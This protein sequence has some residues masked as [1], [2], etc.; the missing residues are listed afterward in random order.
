MPERRK[1]PVEPVF[2]TAAPVS[3][4]AAPRPSPMPS[5]LPSPAPI[6]SPALTASPA[7]SPPPSPVPSP[8][9]SPQATP[10]VTP[11]VTTR[12][13]RIALFLTLTVTI[14]FGA[15]LVHARLQ[16]GSQSMAQAR[17]GVLGMHVER[18][19]SSLLVSWNRQA[20]E[21]VQ[22][23]AA[24]FSIV[25]GERGR[26][27]TLSPH[28]LRTGSLLYTVS[29]EDIEMELNVS[30]PAGNFAESV[31]VVGAAP[32]EQLAMTP[33]LPRL[34][35]EPPAPSGPALSGPAPKSD[36]LRV[37]DA[38]PEQ[39]KARRD[40]VQ[41]PPVKREDKPIATPPEAPE[42]QVGANLPP[43]VPIGVPGLP[44]PGLPLRT[45]APGDTVDYVAPRS[46][47]SAQPSV[48]ASSTSVE[49]AFA[50]T[51]KPH[52]VQVEVTI[53]ERGAVT[54]ATVAASS[55][56]FAYLFVDAALAAARRWQFEPARRG[57]RPVA[58]KMTLK[59]DFVNS[60]R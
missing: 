8:P 39:R 36:D 57:G 4:A 43:A 15:Y 56:P 20:P 30:G 23:S 24:K 35:M 25:S 31:R 52:S 2:V 53:D 42:I 55:G 6:A 28:E 34:T 9:P 45:T 1:K 17:A 13:G 38:A 14:S 12:N 18:Q 11:E 50:Q 16:P 29:A 7:P 40:F 49:R 44:A 3:V 27:L 19:G 48:S 22:A 37:V 60:S 10:Q 58:S 32:G 5:R 47:R 21:I 46:I 41:P 59:F 26:T 51:N 54:N 33:V